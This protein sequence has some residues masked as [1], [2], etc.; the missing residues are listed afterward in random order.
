MS[1]RALRAMEL[2]GKDQSIT[3]EEFEQYKFDLR[4]SEDSYMSLFVDRLISL[5]DGFDDDQL[6][7]G[8]NILKSWDRNTDLDNKN[9][10]LPI[11]SFGWFMETLP[12]D[13]SDE[14]L[15]ESFTYA[16]KYLYN[17]YGKLD[18]IWG[19]VN[20]LVRGSLNLA[21]AGGPD[22]SRAIYGIPTEGGYLK[23]YAGDAFHMLVEWGIDGAVN[24]RS[25]HQYGSN[26]QHETSSHYSDQSK[27]F[28][29]R[30]LKPVWLKLHTIKENLEQAYSPGNK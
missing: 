30:K 25:I 14:N 16:V 29:E 5:S 2:F 17:H 21:V 9:A 19:K 18:V 3:A 15:I 1:N 11:I 13:V 22:I 10:A 27:L 28:V 6:Q 24:S 26:T 12:T 20:R 23:G 4:Y 7:E 8:V